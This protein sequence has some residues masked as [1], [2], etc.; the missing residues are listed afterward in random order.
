LCFILDT[1]MSLL[2]YSSH[3]SLFDRNF[4]LFLAGRCPEWPHTNIGGAVLAAADYQSCPNGFR[5]R[6]NTACK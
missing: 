3:C 5:R 4:T 1:Y 2:R 6:R